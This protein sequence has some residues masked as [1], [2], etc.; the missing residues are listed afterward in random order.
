MGKLQIEQNHV[1]GNA[2]FLKPLWAF[3]HVIVYVLTPVLPKAVVTE[4]VLQ[5]MCVS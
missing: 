3:T 1:I 2:L 4:V 5:K